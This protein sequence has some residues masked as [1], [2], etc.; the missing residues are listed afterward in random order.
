MRLGEFLSQ[1]VWGLAFAN[2][3]LLLVLWVP[4]PHFENH[5]VSEGCFSYFFFLCDDDPPTLHVN[6]KHGSLPGKFIEKFGRF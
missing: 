5:L 3:H 1:L 6:G 4:R 2:T